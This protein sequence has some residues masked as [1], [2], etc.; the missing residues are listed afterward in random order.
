MG[1]F[2]KAAIKM[3]KNKKSICQTSAF[4]ILYSLRAEMAEWQTR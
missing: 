1:C 2:K 3:Q 4:M